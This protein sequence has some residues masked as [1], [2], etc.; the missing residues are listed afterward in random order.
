MSIN[1][2]D[3]QQQHERLTGGGEK[4]KSTSQNTKNTSIPNKRD[5]PN[6]GS[7][8]IQGIGFSV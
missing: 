1:P 6:Q 2:V 3:L 4:S 5:T 7:M 8:G